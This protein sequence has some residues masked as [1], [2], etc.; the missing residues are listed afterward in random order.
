MNAQY[1]LIYRVDNTGL[2]FQHIQFRRLEK[3]SKNYLD[4]GK[5]T[6]EMVQN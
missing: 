2:K 6:K 5:V 3:F 1:N 4:A